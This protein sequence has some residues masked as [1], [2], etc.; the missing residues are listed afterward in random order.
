MQ[1]S[2][3][4]VA[5]DQQLQDGRYW[6]ELHQEVDKITSLL[7]TLNA[8][9]IGWGLVG[10]DGAVFYPRSR[11]WNNQK[12]QR[13]LNIWNPDATF[14]ATC[15]GFKLLN[16]KVEFLRIRLFDFNPR[17]PQEC[18]PASQELFSRLN[19]VQDIIEKTAKRG[20]DQLTSNYTVAGNLEKIEKGASLKKLGAKA[21]KGL[22]RVH[23]Q[24]ATKLFLQ[25]PAEVKFVGVEAVS[26]CI[27]TLNTKYKRYSGQL[28]QVSWD[29]AR[30]T[31]LPG[32]LLTDS[33]EDYRVANKQ[34]RRMV[35]M[36]AVCAKIP[37]KGRNIPAQGGNACWSPLRFVREGEKFF[38]KRGEGV[39]G[40][41][42]RDGLG[43]RRLCNVYFRI[44]LYTHHLTICTGAVDSSSQA[45]E[46]VEGIVEIQTTTNPFANGRWMLHTVLSSD[47]EEEKFEGVHSHLSNIQQSLQQKLKRNDISILQFYTRFNGESTLHPYSLKSSIHESL[48]F[49]TEY[50]LSDAMQLLKSLPD[51]PFLPKEG[52]GFINKQCILICS[53]A[54]EIR[55][56]KND[57]LS[58]EASELIE[59][60]LALENQVLFLTKK[61]EDIEDHSAV[62]LAALKEK[63]KVIGEKIPEEIRG[64]K[65][66]LDRKQSELH[67]ALQKMTEHFGIAIE[68]F[69]NILTKGNQAPIAQAQLL[70]KVMH[71]ILSSQL[72]LP[73]GK[74][75]SR[76]AE[77]ECMLLLYRLL[78]FKVVLVSKSGLDDALVVAAMDDSQSCLERMF[79]PKCGQNKK[80]PFPLN[81]R[82]IARNKLFGLIL[83]MDANRD[84]LFDL[85][86]VREDQTSGE[87]N[88]R[89]LIEKIE[90][91]YEKDKERLKATFFYLELMTAHL[92]GTMGEIMLNSGGVVGQKSLKQNRAEHRWGHEPDFLRRLAPYVTSEGNPIKLL[93]RGPSNEPQI[94][95][96]GSAVI[97]RSSS[98]RKH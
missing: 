9:W 31:L 93:G 17:N 10:F 52:G 77:M 44:D 62:T 59:E 60:L 47:K 82:F 50:V 54:A 48:A 65:Q 61:R 2:P 76:C 29:A 18:S 39:A 51:L 42:R 12:V 84:C 86:H 3:P 14:T 66:Q 98:S 94:T 63:L 68:M 72:K 67:A 36:G 78:D 79:Y 73:E 30:G 8:E 24:L 95:D 74:A 92:I 37:A 26:E 97:Y 43:S 15:K 80:D 89:L 96:I 57:I 7:T 1:G 20:V 91:G 27:I 6:E 28:R 53:L 70:F 21:F 5:S 88:R 19:D 75:L 22:E 4:I 69:G 83:N 46:L 35:R 71:Q 45:C 85:L 41:C 13:V 34:Q 87:I 49:L 90:K 64:I 40:A 81:E 38:I 25:I 56:I 33:E 32:D 55:K 16:E 11:W 58:N 23:E